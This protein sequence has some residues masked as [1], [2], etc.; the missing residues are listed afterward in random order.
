MLGRGML[1]AYWKAAAE[2]L[3]KHIFNKF[4]KKFG[5]PKIA[6]NYGDSADRVFRDHGTPY[7]DKKTF[8]P[9]D[10]VPFDNHSYYATYV[11]DHLDVV[12]GFQHENTVFVGCK[13]D[14]VGRFSGLGEQGSMTEKTAEGIVEELIKALERDTDYVQ[15]GSPESTR[16]YGI[17]LGDDDANE[18][19]SAR[20]I[21]LSRAYNINDYR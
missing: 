7:I 5:E 1:Y 17:N 11:Q 15:K 8:V 14:S 18:L 4:T 2:T 3:D 20:P 6:L 13:E 9:R 19:K 21:P 10:T 16:P 12:Y